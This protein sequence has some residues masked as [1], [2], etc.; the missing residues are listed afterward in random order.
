[1]CHLLK[2]LHINRVHIHVVAWKWHRQSTG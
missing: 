2:V 1:L